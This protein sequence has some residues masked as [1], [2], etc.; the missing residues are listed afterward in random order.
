MQD[1]SELG[2]IGAPLLSTADTAG[3]DSSYGL[4]FYLV[5]V[6]FFAAFAGL[7]WMIY[8]DYKER[9]SDVG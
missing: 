6:V 7:V 8:E 3:A 2:G 5:I 4:S 1:P 9:R